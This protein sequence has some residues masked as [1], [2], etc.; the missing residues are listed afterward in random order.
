[1]L[2]VFTFNIQLFAQQADAN[3]PKDLF[4]MSLEELMS[5]PIVVSASRLR[6]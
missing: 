3:K 1:V 6:E 2:F 5:V 4:E